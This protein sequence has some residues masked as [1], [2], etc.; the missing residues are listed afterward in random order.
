MPDNIKCNQ[1]NKKL[2]INN[3]NFHENKKTC[4]FNIVK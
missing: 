3:H 1:N 2:N 4:D